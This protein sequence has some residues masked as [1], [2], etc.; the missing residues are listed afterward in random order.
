LNIEEERKK[1]QHIQRNIDDG[2]KPKLE[3]NLNMIYKFANLIITT[4]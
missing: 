1:V 2:E 4:N 3:L